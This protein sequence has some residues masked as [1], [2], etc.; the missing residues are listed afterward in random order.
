MAD[1]DVGFTGVVGMNAALQA[2]L[3]IASEAERAVAGDYWET[4]RLN[5]QRRRND[6]AM[7]TEARDVDESGDD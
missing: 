2:D 5:Q 3:A 1:R 7:N 4:G 6:V